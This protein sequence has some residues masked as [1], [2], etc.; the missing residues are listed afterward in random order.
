M[1]LPILAASES[2]RDALAYVGPDQS[3]TYGQLVEDVERQAHDI[4][5][6]KIERSD[7]VALAGVN[8]YQT[9]VNMWAIWWL[10]AVACPMSGRYSSQQSKEISD[11]LECNPHRPGKI[12]QGRGSQSCE[13]A[14]DAPA[15]IILSS[16]STGIPKAIVH[17]LSAHVASASGAAKNMPLEAGDRWLW[18]LPVYHVSGL[19]I[20]VRCATAGATLVAAQGPLTSAEIGK[21]NITHLSL[22]STQLRRLLQDSDFPHANLKAVLVGG[23]TVPPSLVELARRRGVPACT[24][25]GMTET[26]SQVTTS[27]VECPPTTSGRVLPRREIKIEDGEI[28]VRGETLCMGYWQEDGIRSVVDQQ[29]WL[30]TGDLGSIDADGRL[31]VTGRRDNMFIS[32]G[33][34]IYPETIEKALHELDGVEQAI[35]VPRADDEFG[36]RPIAFVQGDLRLTDVWNTELGKRLR[37]FEIPDEYLAWPA[38]L[39]SGIKPNR[40]AMRVA[41]ATANNTPSGD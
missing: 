12:W 27:T 2:H 11:R 19:S 14:A 23:S 10:G 24:T 3:A 40:E 32:G 30:H 21:L 1:M 15:T 39:Q 35:V 28:L 38:D 7:H 25:Y 34:N 13:F 26:A 16:G 20:L 33:E 22:V 5:R 36:Q 29:G 8:D 31:T 41:A 9:L 4:A 6:C 17:S 18:S 37:S